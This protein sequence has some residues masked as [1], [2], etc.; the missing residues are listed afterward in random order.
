[1]CK[2]PSSGGSS[3]ELGG[4]SVEAMVRPNGAEKSDNFSGKQSVYYIVADIKLKTDYY[5][6]V[7]SH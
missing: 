6:L 4:S 2:I 3:L 7:V 5:K 1:M